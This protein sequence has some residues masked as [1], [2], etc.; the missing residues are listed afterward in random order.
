MSAITDETT[1]DLK[2]DDRP[3]SPVE[4]RNSLEKHLQMRPDAKDLKNRNILLDTKVAPYGSVL[5][6]HTVTQALT[7]T[8]PCRLHN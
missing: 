5:R 4:R 6:F 7:T 2:V 1:P 3:I 8:G